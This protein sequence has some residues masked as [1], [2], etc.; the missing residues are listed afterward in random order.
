MMNTN[1]KDFNLGLAFGS[2][3]YGIRTSFNKFSGAGVNAKSTV[4][5]AFAASD[6]LS[7]LVWSPH[8]GLILKCANSRLADKKPILLWNVIP[9]SQDLSS[10]Q[11]IR[12]KGSEDDKGNALDQGNLTVSQQML[13][14]DDMIVDKATLAR[15]S[16]S[17]STPELRASH[18][19]CG[20]KSNSM[21]DEGGTNDAIR[22]ERNCMDEREKELCRPQSIQVKDIAEISKRNS[23]FNTSADGIS[24]CK[25]DVAMNGLFSSER[26]RKLHCNQKSNIEI[27]VSSSDIMD[28]DVANPEPLATKLSET[29][30]CSLPNS[31]F[32]KEAHHKVISA[33]PLKKH[34]S[35]AENDLSHLSAKEPYRL[36][37]MKHP[38][39]SSYSPH[40]ERSPTNSK[41]C[42]YQE[43]GKEKALSDGD[44]YGR[45]SNNDD[46]SRESVES[47]NSAEL[48]SRGIKRLSYD[49]GLILGSKR[50]KKQVDENLGSTSTVRPDSSFKNWIS[51]MVKG[52]SDSNKEDTSSLAVTLACPNDAYGENNQDNFLCKKTH[53]SASPNTGFQTMFQSLYCRNTIIS[54]N[55]VQHENHNSTEESRE[56]MVAEKTSVENLAGSSHRNDDNFCKQIVVADKEINPVVV[57][58][59]PYVCKNN[60]AENK[61]SEVLVSNGTKDG[62]S[63]SDSSGKQMNSSAGKMTHDV[64]VTASHVAEK[65]NPLTSVWITRLSARTHMVETHDKLTQETNGCSTSCPNINLDTQVNNVFPIDQKSPEAKGDMVD[66][67]VYASFTAKAEASVELKLTS[68][69]FPMLPSQ[70]FQSSEAM[71]SVFARRLD[72]LRHIIPSEKQNSSTYLL[73]CFFCGSGHDLRDCPDVTE[74]ELE[75]FLVKMS[76]FEKVQESP[77]LCI[78]C[79]QLDHWAIS[80]PLGPPSRNWRSERDASVVRPCTSRHLHL[81]AGKEKCSSHRVEEEDDK[82]FAADPKACSRK[83]CFGSFRCYQTSNV[84]STSNRIQIHDASRLANDVKNDKKFPLYNTVTAQNTVAPSIEIFRAIRN[85]RLSR[86][87]IL[88]W[89]NSDISLSHLNGFFLRLR[90]GKLEAGLGGASYYVACITGDAREPNGCRS[91]KSILV[92]VGG[93]K[94]SVGS[95]YVSNHDFLEDEIK[96]WF[97]TIVKNGCSIPSLDK[98]NSKFNDK[99]SL[100]F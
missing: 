45:S 22:K 44:I 73:T 92:D 7:E 95:Q 76:S 43:K 81:H 1:N 68:K 28:L 79:F 21:M 18:G 94:S 62:I 27:H 20:E 50:M 39:G 36:D 55:G 46:D 64:P 34:E 84:L 49:H 56:L 65:N 42:L 72:A 99:K 100:G 83:P 40:V 6:P 9:A 91:K 12:S 67:Q 88:R 10:L 78:R 47:C 13:V 66:C 70:K 3:R 38:R 5:M 17:F 35:P 15:P 87:D 2:T 4:D 80:C 86:A 58:C 19:D 69:L 96:T 98:L 24:D 82:F 11:S 16:T 52:P 31:Q 41:I 29:L 90:L 54:N 53:D 74:T 14:A 33:T 63:R 23:G 30:V 32:M 26:S 59:F 97:C 85:L 77:C 61:A 37:E 25:L 48:F 60:L 75:D 8:N 93:I 51:N 71:A 89:I 57:D